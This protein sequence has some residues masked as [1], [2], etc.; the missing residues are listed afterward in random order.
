MQNL[1]GAV[2][3]MQYHLNDMLKV[4][5]MIPFSEEVLLFFDDLSKVLIK[6]EYPAVVAF[7][8]WCRKASLMQAGKKYDDITQRLGRGIVFHITPSNVPVNFAYSL[9]MGLLAGNA[10]IVRLPSKLF[11]EVSV[12]ENAIEELYGTKHKN[13]KPYII[14]V[15]YSHDIEVTNRLSSICDSRVIWGGDN[16]IKEIRKSPLPSRA[17]EITFADR[18]SITMINADKYLKIENKE[19]VAQDFYN[20]TYLTDQTACTSPKLVIWV[21]NKKEAAKKEFWEHVHAL[22]AEKYNL[23][24]IQSVT[25]LHNVCKMANLYDNVRLEPHE[26]G[27]I[28]RVKVDILEGKLMDCKYNSGFFFEY[29][30]NEWEE[31]LPILTERCQTLTYLGIPWQ[32]IAMFIAEYKPKGIDRVVPMGRSMDF[33]LDWDGVDIIRQLSRKVV[34]V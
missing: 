1:E 7:G 33:S 10:N 13:M 8:F 22:V 16:T 12:I 34:I 27:Y 6:S 25:K 9:A 19:K 26:D 30:A 32:T 15:R 21:G 4:C 23:S 24:P 5:P 18:Y 14:M 28:A 20:D 3:H 29:D 31:I 11:E 17:N 2:T